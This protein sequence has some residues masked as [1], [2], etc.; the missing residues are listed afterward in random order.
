MKIN[1]VPKVMNSMLHCS[2][3]EFMKADGRWG[4]KRME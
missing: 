1:K 2:G 3:T 4:T